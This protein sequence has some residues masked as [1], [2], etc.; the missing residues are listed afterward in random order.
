[1]TELCSLV[2]FQMN[3][4]LNTVLVVT[5]VRILLLSFDAQNSDIRIYR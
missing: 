4:H 1:M 3:A 5:H 2:F